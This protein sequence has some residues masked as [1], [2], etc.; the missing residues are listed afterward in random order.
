[1]PTVRLRDSRWQVQV[2]RDGHPPRTRTFTLKRDAQA[3]ARHSEAHLE[4]G[5]DV[6]PSKAARETLGELVI[7]YRDT[8]SIRKKGFAIEAAIL[9]AF[10]RQPICRKPAAAV[11]NADFARYRDQRLANVLPVTLSREFCILHKMFEVAR[12]EW[13]LGLSA[14]P[15]RA[16]RVGPIGPARQRRLQPGEEQKLIGIASRARNPLLRPAFELAIQTGLRRSELLA[17]TWS[18]VD[19]EGRYVRIPDSKNGHPRNV[20]LTYG[21]IEVLRGLPRSPGRVFPMSPNALQVGLG[22]RA[23]SSRLS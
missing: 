1:M 4:R 18:D 11:T 22:T 8:V 14:N 2:R 9:G 10:L 5:E 20:V 21:A 16:V 23:P 19:L 15:L 6:Q 17:L 3:W 7:R 12:G 13:G